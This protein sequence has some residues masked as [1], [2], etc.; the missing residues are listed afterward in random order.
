M[1]QCAKC[2]EEIIAGMLSDNFKETIKNFIANDEAYS[3]MNSVKLS[4]AY[5]KD[6]LSDVLAMA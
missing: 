1:F 2:L 4:P 3:F 5:W 6:M